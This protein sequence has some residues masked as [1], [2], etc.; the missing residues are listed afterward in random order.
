MPI[1][2]SFRRCPFAIRARLVLQYCNIAV[3]LREV[4]LR[5]KPECMLESSS[6][7]T[8]PVL[9]LDDGT[10]IDESWDIM[11]WSLRKNDADNWLGQDECY[12]GDA[13]KLVSMNDY[14]FKDKLD[15]YKYADR[16]PD[17][18]ARYYRAQLEI[19]LQSLDKRLCTNRYLSGES[20]SIADISIFPF[21]RQL[22]FVDKPWF[23]GASFHYLQVWL[24][25]LLESA[26]F[27]S[28]MVKYPVW[29]P[30]SDPQVCF[31]K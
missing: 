7:G 11:L 2:Y 24:E 8:V 22:A 30:G 28:V 23:D 31:G 27:L 4:L 21:I 19:F 13:I 20:I 18:S 16:H 15:C 12:L 9:I 29:Q 5:N 17:H 25:K 6:K 10:V 14:P 1:L 26:L 3:E